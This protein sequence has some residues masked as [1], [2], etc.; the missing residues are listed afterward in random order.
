MHFIL[1][2]LIYELF[3]TNLK[4]LGALRLVKWSHIMLGRKRQLDRCW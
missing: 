1:N 4:G 2:S 3:D